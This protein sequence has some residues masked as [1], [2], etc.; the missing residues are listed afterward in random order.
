MSV[1]YVDRTERILVNSERSAP[2][3]V[4]RPAERGRSSPTPAVGRTVVV[5]AISGHLSSQH[6]LLSL[7]HASVELHAGCSQ[8]HECLLQ[9]RVDGREFVQPYGVVVGQVA[10]PDGVKST[11]NHRPVTVL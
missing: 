9:R 5:V 6:R 1:Q 7:G 2:A 3:K 4:T 8:F 11:D 10:D